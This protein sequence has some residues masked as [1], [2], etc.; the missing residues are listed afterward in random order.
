MPAAIDRVCTASSSAY[1]YIS[2]PDM[3]QQLNEIQHTDITY[4]NKR[5]GSRNG[6]FA[7]AN[8]L[9]A[10]TQNFSIQ[11]YQAE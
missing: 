9:I 6:A 4:N 10:P 7:A 8:A 11:Q 1:S 2:K 5:K 3:A